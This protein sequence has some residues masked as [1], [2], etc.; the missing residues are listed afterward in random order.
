MQGVCGAASAGAA[1][2]ATAH[3]AVTA[4]P[5][6]ATT[7]TTAAIFFSCIIFPFPLHSYQFSGIGCFVPKAQGWKFLIC[8]ALSIMEFSDVW[9]TSRMHDIEIPDTTASRYTS[10]RNR[11]PILS[12]IRRISGGS[13]SPSPY[14][15]SQDQSMHGMTGG[16]TAPTAGPQ[17]KTGSNPGLHSFFSS[18]RRAIGS[19]SPMDA[20]SSS[21]SQSIVVSTHPSVFV[22]TPSVII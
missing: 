14:S 12:R 16:L 1:V 9:R 7:R 15:S 17:T 11:M 2:A 18:S 22:T 6:A 8:S 4:R 3:P 20:T 19:V 21:S 5:S 10:R 13:K